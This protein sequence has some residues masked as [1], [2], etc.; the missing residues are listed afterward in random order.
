[1]QKR[2]LSLKLILNKNK[3]HRSV[4]VYLFEKTEVLIGVSTP[5]TFIVCVRFS[6]IMSKRLSLFHVVI[7]LLKRELNKHVLVLKYKCCSFSNCLPL[8][9]ATEHKSYLNLPICSIF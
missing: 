1:M 4:Y 8:K 3:Q 5:L 9:I 2:T 6:V 7:C